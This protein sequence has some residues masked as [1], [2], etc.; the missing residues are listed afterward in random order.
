MLFMLNAVKKALDGDPATGPAHDSTCPFSEGCKRHYSPGDI[1]RYS[2]AIALSV[3]LV[4][5]VFSLFFPTIIPHPNLAILR[6]F[7][8]ILHHAVTMQPI[9][10]D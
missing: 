4:L 7:V 2:I 8:N 5:L 10:T 3:F 6:E 9:P 1:V